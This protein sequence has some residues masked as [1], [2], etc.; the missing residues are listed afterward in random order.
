MILVL[1]LMIIAAIFFGGNILAALRGLGVWNQAYNRLSVRYGGKKKAG[2]VMYGYALTNPSLIIDY[3]RTNCVLRNGHSNRFTGRRQTELVMNWP[4]RK[5]RMEISSGLSETA[6]W[7]ARGLRSVTLTDADANQPFFKTFHIETNF[8]QFAIKLVTAAVQWQ[9]EKI[10]KLTEH[11]EMLVSISGGQLSIAI[12]GYIKDF[13]RLDDFLQSGLNLFDQMMLV[14]VDGIE[15]LHVNE[16]S[17]VAD[18]KCPICSETITQNMVMC[19]RCKTP[20]CADCWQY[21]GQCA[22]FACR[23]TRYVRVGRA[24]AKPKA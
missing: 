21:N 13:Q 9:L 15:F 4:E 18:V 3:G 23:E 20:H 12:P 1:L 19:N 11:R 22:T 7:A 8:P 17:V 10:L 5:F 2:G 6:H 16:A 24:G 14:N